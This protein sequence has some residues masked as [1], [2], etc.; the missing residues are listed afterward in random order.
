MFK[1]QNLS[2][3]I[4]LQMLYMLEEIGSISKAIE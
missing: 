4:S 1:M 2:R 3:E